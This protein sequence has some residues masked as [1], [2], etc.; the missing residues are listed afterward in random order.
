MRG[1]A[2]EGRPYSFTHPFISVSILSDLGQRGQRPSRG[3]GL[4]GL[5]GCDQETGGARGGDGPAEHRV[6]W[7]ERVQHLETALTVESGQRQPLQ[8]GGTRQVGGEKKNSLKIL[9]LQTAS[10]PLYPNISMAVC[11]QAVPKFLSS[12]LGSRAAHL[13]AC[14]APPPGSLLRDGRANLHPSQR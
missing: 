9:N 1:G 11:G 4:G 12:V 3:P 6:Q 7:E 14:W 5:K 2:V 13:P 8:E 10:E